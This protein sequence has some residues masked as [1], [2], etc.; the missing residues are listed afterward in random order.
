MPCAVLSE[1]LNAHSRS[2]RCIPSGIP[3]RSHEAAFSICSCCKCQMLGC[4]R[5]SPRSRCQEA[6]GSPLYDCDALCQH[7]CEFSS[8]KVPI[9][10]SRCAMHGP[11]LAFRQTHRLQVTN[12]WY[13]ASG[14]PLART[15]AHPPA[16]CR[17][18]RRT[19]RHCK[20]GQCWRVHLR[21][22]G[23]WRSIYVPTYGRFVA[24]V[25]STSSGGCSLP[26]RSDVR[27]CQLFSS[28]VSYSG[29][30]LSRSLSLPLSLSLSLSLS[31]PPPA[32][33]AFSSDIDRWAHGMGTVLDNWLQQSPDV[34]R[35]QRKHAH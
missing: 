34:T 21:S 25:D 17:S 24:T 29:S 4:K 6:S 22:W 30:C 18:R 3:F 7:L 35:A 23:R 14:Y 10:P 32:D 28:P 15:H 20:V 26:Q 19:T 11:D 8:R 27:P 16:L 33:L 13:R 5:S 2:A 9:S 1:G 12:S 31:P